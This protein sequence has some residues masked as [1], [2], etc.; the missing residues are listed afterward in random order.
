MSVQKTT[1]NDIDTLRRN[2]GDRIA[3]LGL[4]RVLPLLLNDIDGKRL[5]QVMKGRM[6]QPSVFFIRDIAAVL[7][8]GVDDLLDEKRGCNAQF[9]R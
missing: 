1:R 5:E 7:H 4:E 9:R 8:T 6:V 2:I 3:F